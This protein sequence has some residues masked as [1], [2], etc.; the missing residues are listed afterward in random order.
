MTAAARAVWQGVSRNGSNGLWSKLTHQPKLSSVSP[1][2]A[3]THLRAVPAAPAVAGEG[4]DALTQAQARIATLEALLHEQATRDPL[5][6]L[7]NQVEFAARL[8]E[9]LARADAENRIVAVGFLDLDRFRTVNDVLGHA[10]GDKLLQEVGQRL[11]DRLGPG[12]VFR[13]AGDEFVLLREWV[14]RDEDQLRLFDAARSAL[15]RPFLCDGH[16]LFMTGTVGT[17][18]FPYDGE[19][20]GTLVRNA[21][22]ALFRAKEQGGDTVEAY[23]RGLY[24]EARR[25]LTMERS[26]R[27]ALERDEIVVH[28]QPMLDLATGTISGFEALAR[29]QHPEL[30]LLSPASFMPLA[31]E[32][33]LVVALGRRVLELACGQAAAWSAARAGLRLWV[34]VSAR[35][36]HHGDLAAVVT[37]ALDGAGLPATHLGLEITESLAM[38]HPTEAAAVLEQLSAIGVQTA[39]DDFGTGHSALAYLGRFPVHV[40]KLDRT[41]VHKAP[42]D[43]THA[44]II[45]AVITLARGLD[46]TVVAEGVET[47]EQRSFVTREGADQAQGF[48]LGRPGPPESFNS[49]V[50][51]Q[52][53]VFNAAAEG[54][55]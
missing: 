54:N 30:G 7:P 44:A 37:G 5:T 6:G 28:Y 1:R 34:N 35:Q 53:V 19:D 48:L 41:F 4:F 36:F 13:M 22:C 21:D 14:S 20:L 55:R 18:L 10:T 46:M 33:G 8:N 51:R 12:N 43:R 47:E 25:R 26:L 27:R 11:V 52:V 17:A 32:T 38:R 3:E 24:D 16:E 15:H 50:N 45:R 42:A 49:V 39:L 2:P 40:L 31:E 23:S 29:W 9:V